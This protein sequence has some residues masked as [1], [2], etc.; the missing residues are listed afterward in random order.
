[1]LVQPQS[2]ALPLELKPARDPG[3][4]SRD[5]IPFDAKLRV[6]AA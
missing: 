3:K 2:A 1:M 5:G 6:V 4:M